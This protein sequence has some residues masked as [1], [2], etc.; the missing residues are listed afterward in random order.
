MND[1][2]HIQS[3][4]AAIRIEN[5]DTD[6]IVPK[7]FLTGIDKSGLAKALLYD[8]RFDRFGVPKP[9]F[10]LNRPEYAGARV[11]IGGANFGCGSSREHAIWSLQQFG[12]R[13][14]IAPSF[15]EIFYSNAMNNQLLL[16]MLPREA[17]D[18]LMSEVEQSPGTEINIDIERRT[19]SSSRGTWPFNLSGRHREMFLRNLDVIGLTLQKKQQIESFSKAHFAKNP[20]L[21]DIASRNRLRLA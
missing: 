5:L 15:G 10:V 19:V 17:I 14:V 7:Q 13:A 1:H 4:G 20:W 18:L 12:I 6:Q 3:R 8:L 16:V 2:T 21:S 9:G 11:L